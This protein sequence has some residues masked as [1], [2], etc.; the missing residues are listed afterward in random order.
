MVAYSF[1]KAVAPQVE[2]LVKRQTVRGH[3]RRHARPG[4]P[5]QLYTGMR[6]RACRKL[7]SPDP[8]CTEVLPV[9]LQISDRKIEPD[10]PPNWIE[11]VRIDGRLLAQE[12]VEQFAVADG[13]GLEWFTKPGYRWHR[14]VT[15]RFIMSAYFHAMEG[16][17]LFEGVLIKWEPQS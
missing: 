15:P 6:T 10:A 5:V 14:Y 9:A 8:L 2:A 13:F 4:E 17:G 11:S 3:R 12:A 1:S 16:A 7:L